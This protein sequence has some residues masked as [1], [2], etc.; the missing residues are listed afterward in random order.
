MSTE[1]ILIYI[2]IYT[3]LDINGLLW[4]ATYDDGIVG[5]WNW[6]SQTFWYRSTHCNESIIYIFYTYICIYVG[7]YIIYLS[8]YV[9]THIYMYLYIF[10]SVWCGNPTNPSCGAALV[11]S[12]QDR[13]KRG[14]EWR[15]Y[16]CNEGDRCCMTFSALANRSQIVL[17]TKSSQLSSLLVLCRPQARPKVVWE[18]VCMWHP[19]SARRG[20]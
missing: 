13:S 6:I 18:L 10:F 7:M 16:S 15:N 19:T 17:G 2:Y 3:H 14:A 12:F 1:Y 9:C 8:I 20:P 11:P 5:K 4:L